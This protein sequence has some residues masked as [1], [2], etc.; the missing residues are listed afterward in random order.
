M[1]EINLFGAHP[2]LGEEFRSTPSYIDLSETGPYI[3]QICEMNQLQLNRFIKAEQVLQKVN[4]SLSGDREHRQSLYKS[5]ALSEPYTHIAID[6][7]VPAGTPLYAPFDCEVLRTEY[8]KAWE[9]NGGFGGWLQ[10]EVIGR[11]FYIMVGH[12]KHGGHLPGVGT[13][14]KAGEQ[15]AITGDITENGGWFEH[16]HFQVLTQ[17][18]FDE[19]LIWG[20][21]N[22]NIYPDVDIYSPDPM[23]IIQACY[24]LT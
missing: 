19:K 21:V 4:W 10:M 6:I 17:Q 8:D 9:G 23:P 1:P 3:N 12:L 15:V 5:F 24:S 14:I 13:I 22:P 18:A 2:I 16:A 20:F 7:I 11:G